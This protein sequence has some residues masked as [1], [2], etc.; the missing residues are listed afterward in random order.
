MNVIANFYLLPYIDVG[1][2]IET[3]GEGDISQVCG[4]LN[5][6]KP[7]GSS[8][9]SRGTITLEEV[10]AEGLKRQNPAYYEEQR[11]AGYIKGV[12]EDRPAV[13]SVN[14]QFGA[15]GR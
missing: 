10:R 4:Y 9:L 11:R 15:F 1:V 7:G 5:Y 2:T 8:L 6:L 13:I 3:E 12:V 14:M